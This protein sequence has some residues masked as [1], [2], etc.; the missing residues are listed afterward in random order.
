MK[1]FMSIWNNKTTNSYIKYKINSS[2]TTWFIGTFKCWSRWLCLSIPWRWN[3][4]FFYFWGTIFTG[5]LAEFNI[6]F[7]KFYLNLF[8]FSKKIVQIFLLLLSATGI[9]SWCVFQIV[10]LYPSS[11]KTLIGSLIS[12]RLSE[13][14]V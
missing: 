4:F 13:N 9:W 5:L 6:I 2:Y 11:F 1:N 10:S 12:F 8:Y 3:K 7:C 14:F